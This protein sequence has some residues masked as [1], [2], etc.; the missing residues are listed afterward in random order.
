MTTFCNHEVTKG[1]LRAEATHGHTVQ[2]VQV[3]LHVSRKYYIFN[4]VFIRVFTSTT[5]VA[6]VMETNF[7]DTVIIHPATV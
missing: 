4:F 6:S 2:Q 7:D 1:H 3:S 5:H